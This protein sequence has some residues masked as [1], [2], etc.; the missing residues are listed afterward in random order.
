LQLGLGR[1][2]VVGIERALG[3]DQRGHRRIGGAAELRFHVAGGAQHLGVVLGF[4]GGLQ[5]VVQRRGLAGL[6]ALVV[7]P[8]VPAG[9]RS[10]AAISTQVVS[11]A[12]LV[13]PGFEG[14]N[15]SCSSRSYAMFR[16]PLSLALVELM[17]AVLVVHVVVVIAAVGDLVHH[18]V[19]Y[20]VERHRGLLLFAF[21]RAHCFDAGGVVGDFIFADDDGKRGAAPSAFF[22]CDLK[23]PAPASVEPCMITS[24]P[25]R[26][27]ARPARRLAAA[28]SP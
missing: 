16:L 20:L 23:L 17:V 7:V 10:Q 18:E 12:V 24:R 11:I 5:L 21:R 15:C 13:P 26:A 25:H 8:A 6:V 14:R 1:F 27:G 9:V 4:H 19:Y 28:P 3:G 22:I 2:Q